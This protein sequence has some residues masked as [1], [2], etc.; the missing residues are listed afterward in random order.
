[1]KI[2]IY[3][4]DVV[5]SIYAARLHG[6][7]HDVTI[8]AAGNRLADLRQHGV[9]LRHAISGD[10]LFL[11]IHLIEGLSR[12][13]QYDVALVTVP[14]YDLPNLPPELI[15]NRHIGTLLV[16]TGHF[17]ACESWHNVLNRDRVLLGC[18]GFAGIMSGAKV[19]YLPTPLLLQRATIGALD[20]HALPH[21]RTAMNMFRQAGLY[22]SR[23]N[24]IDALLRTQAAIFVS[25]AAGVEAAQSSGVQAGYDP[26][27]ARLVI[28][29]IRDCFA[30]LTE[31]QL[32]VTPRYLKWISSAPLK[33]LA[34][35]LLQWSRTV[36]FHMTV[37]APLTAAGDEVRHLADQFRLL[38][39]LASVE[40]PAFDELAKNFTVGRDVSLYAS[41]P[42]CV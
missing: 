21:L 4:G 12:C 25:L 5:G 16:M 9:V 33:S 8:L 13:D 32:P 30:V 36:E 39:M 24:R 11:H 31:L 1:M 10:E 29:S 6:P 23:C 3:G 41:Q 7:K 20:D 35:L 42:V 17:G 34:D 22:V 40:T 2:L 26:N 18:P 14:S 38:S 19:E 37:A 28:R 15:C 27:T